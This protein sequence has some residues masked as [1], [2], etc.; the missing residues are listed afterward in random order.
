MKRP[1][2]PAWRAVLADLRSASDRLSS[3][4]GG[5][6][7]APPIA[8][9]VLLAAVLPATGLAACGGGGS[10]TSLS[11]ASGAASITTT[12]SS[13]EWSRVCSYLTAATRGVAALRVKGKGAFALFHGPNASKY[14]MPMVNEG[15]A[16]KMSQLAPV[17]YP[18]G[19][20][21]AAP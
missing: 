10:S 6:R 1:T 9:L 17:A 11:A 2:H 15:G 13:R 19:A 5:R 18:L 3:N 14:V 8:A 20:P 7:D 16:W 12:T 4:E 21:G